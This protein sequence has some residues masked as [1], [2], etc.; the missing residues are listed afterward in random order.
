MKRQR[1][2]KLIIRRMALV[3]VDI[4]SVI[5]ASF[6][7]LATRFEFVVPEIPKE[8]IE[9][10]L[11]YLPGFVGISLI[12]FALFELLFRRKL[13]KKLTDGLSMAFMWLFLALMVTLVFRDV[14]RSRRIHRAE[15]EY[16]RMKRQLRQA[17]EKAKQFRP[18]FDLGGEKSV[19]QGR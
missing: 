3:V 14:T 18:A 19:R 1:D 11:F 12:L 17:E 5:F 10:L 2:Y 16:E 7:A 13:P 6:F 4:I 8:F 9:S 15:A